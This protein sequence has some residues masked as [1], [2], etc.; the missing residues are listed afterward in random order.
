MLFGL[1]RW[2]RAAVLLSYQRPPSADSRLRVM[3]QVSAAIQLRSRGQRSAVKCAQSSSSGWV[4]NWSR[5]RG[6]FG[7]LLSRPGI[8]CERYTDWSH[9]K[10]TRPP[11]APPPPSTAPPPHSPTQTPQK[12]SEDR[13]EQLV[14]G[15]FS[16]SVY[17]PLVRRGR[18]DRDDWPEQRCRARTH[19]KVRGWNSFRLTPICLVV[20]GFIPNQN[21]FIYAHGKF[22]G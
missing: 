19:G 14:K 17:F 16:S 22:C 21:T 11:T 6:G 12:P 2:S 5:Q 20:L 18:S 8:T 4:T 1:F 10:L 9:N 7:D 3:Q 13:R 15:D